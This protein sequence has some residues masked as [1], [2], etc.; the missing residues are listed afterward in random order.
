LSAGRSG[1]DGIAGQRIGARGRF[2]SELFGRVAEDPPAAALPAWVNDRT[3][4]RRGELLEHLGAQTL[5]IDDREAS[6]AAPREAN[7]T[8]EAT[9]LPV[10]DR[11]L[12][13]AQRS[14]GIANVQ[15]LSSRHRDL[16]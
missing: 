3:L 8:Q 2:P 13:H 9:S 15:K 12:V 11:V 6:E 10:A 7:G 4:R 14:G 1:L 16:P 5:H